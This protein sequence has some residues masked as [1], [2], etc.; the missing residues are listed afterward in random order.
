[1]SALFFINLPKEKFM[2]MEPHKVSPGEW[3]GTLLGEVKAGF[4]SPAEDCREEFDLKSLVVRHPAATFYFVVDGCSM[5]DAGMD[6]GD[7][8]VVDK[9]LEPYDGC[10]AI[11]YLD[12]G[13]TVKKVSLGGDGITLLPM[14]GDSGRFR[15]IKVSPEDRFTVWGVVTYVI[16]K[17]R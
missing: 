6:D 9:S 12:G 7:I 3:D 13:Y 8:I 1:M 10:K 16:K 11:C 4:P 2:D 5:V 15:P 17:I 14:N